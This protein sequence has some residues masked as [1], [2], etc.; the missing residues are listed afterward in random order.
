MA[1]EA[2]EAS[3][4][5][6]GTCTINTKPALILFDSGAS[7]SFILKDFVAKHRFP[8][9]PL[10]HLLVIQTPASEMKTNTMCQDL[11]ISINQVKFPAQL[12]TLNVP[13]LDAILGM[14]WLV[15][16]AAQ[17]DCATR[18]VTLTNPEGIRT[19]YVPNKPHQ[20]NAKMFLAQARR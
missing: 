12:S 13:G 1:E 10:G 8:V 20:I 18:A 4:V 9:S 3:D 15:Q 7:H 14:D 16:H 19:T 11:T 5:V 6:L 17:I 2:F